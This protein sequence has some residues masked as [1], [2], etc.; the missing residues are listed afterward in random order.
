M[1]EIIG[2]EKMRGDLSDDNWELWYGGVG[3]YLV[4]R[5]GGVEDED[6]VEGIRYH[7]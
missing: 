1:K 6:I 3:G 5:E 2:G 7:T 4:E